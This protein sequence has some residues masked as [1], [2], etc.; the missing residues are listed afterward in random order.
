MGANVFLVIGGVLVTPPE[1]DVL[2]GIT[3]A[4]VMELARDAGVAVD[5]RPIHR[6]ET[7]RATEAFITSTSLC[8]CPVVSIDDAT[9]GD[10]AIPGP[11]TARLQRAFQ[12]LVGVDFVAQYLTRL[13]AAEGGG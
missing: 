13:D 5:D 10:G 3:R 2:P 8:I 11:L 1:R 6:T 7:A 12:Q 9:V 4:V